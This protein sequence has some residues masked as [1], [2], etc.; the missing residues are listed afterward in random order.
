MGDEDIV[1]IDPTILYPANPIHSSY[2]FGGW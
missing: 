1:H 2:G